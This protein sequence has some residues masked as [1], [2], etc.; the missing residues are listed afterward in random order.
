MKFEDL[1][2]ENNKYMMGEHAFHMFPNYYG[3]S[4]I[5]GQ[6]TYGGKKGRYEIAV[7]HMGPND[8]ESTIMYDT[9][10]TNDVI[11]YLTP[12]DVTDIMKQVSELPIRK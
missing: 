7:I 10:I 6:Y 5:R 9:P 11:G 4:V 3:V 2:F 1:T 12:E 8:T